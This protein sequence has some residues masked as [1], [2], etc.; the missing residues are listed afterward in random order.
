MNVWVGINLTNFVIIWIP[1]NFHT[2]HF[3]LLSA[4]TLLPSVSLLRS[5]IL[6]R[7]T[8]KL[9]CKFFFSFLCF[10]IFQLSILWYLKYLVISIWFYQLHED[11]SQCELVYIIVTRD[12]CC[13]RPLIYTHLE[14]KIKLK[15]RI[16][17][18]GRAVVHYGWIP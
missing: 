15:F 11:E 7:L 13:T 6:R 8:T 17:I 3:C 1:A 16:L 14:A 5:F 9:F 18:R 12:R 10:V 2:V 4:V